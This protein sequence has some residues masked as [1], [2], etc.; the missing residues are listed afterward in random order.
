MDPE[1]YQETKIEQDVNA[2][3]ADLTDGTVKERVKLA[4]FELYPYVNEERSAQD[5]VRVEWFERDKD[6]RK[7]PRK[8]HYPFGR[9]LLEGFAAMSIPPAIDTENY[10]SNEDTLPAS[11]ESELP[12]EL[13][14]RPTRLDDARRRII[15]A[16]EALIRVYRLTPKQIEKSERIARNLHSSPRY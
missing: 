10:S 2:V 4:A 13:L 11:S 12:D 8:P 6:A 14:D 15:M 7:A 16:K 1:S 5:E 3:F 9:L